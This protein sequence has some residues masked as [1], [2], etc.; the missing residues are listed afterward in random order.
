MDKPRLNIR[1]I[2]KRHRLDW[3]LLRLIQRG[4]IYLLNAYAKDSRE[5]HSKMDSRHKPVMYFRFDDLHSFSPHKIHRLIFNDRNR[6]RL[7]QCANNAIRDAVHIH[8]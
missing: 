5:N 4:H 3:A 6:Y 8:P 7:G 1:H 2:C